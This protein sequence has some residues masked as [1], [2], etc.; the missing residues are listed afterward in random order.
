MLVFG[1]GLSSCGTG[2]TGVNGAE[3]QA[4]LP[5][6]EEA[7][8]T[9]SSPNAQGL[10]TIVGSDAVPDGATIIAD[11]NASTSLNLS[12]LR[13]LADLMIPTAA[14]SDCSSALEGLSECPDVNGEGKCYFVADAEGDASFQVPADVGDTIAI[15]YL[16]PSTCVETDVFEGA[17]IDDDT[18]SLGM[19]ALDTAFD[20]ENGRVYA[21]GIRTS[22]DTTTPFTYVYSVVDATTREVAA[23]EEISL[24]DSLVGI[25]E[26]VF[27]FPSQGG[28]DFFF[29]DGSDGVLI[30]D[31]TDATAGLPSFVEFTGVNGSESTDPDGDLDYLD[32]QDFDTATEA[33]CRTD[34]PEG[35]ESYTRIFYT[36][37][38][39]LFVQEFADIIDDVAPRMVSLSVT[40]SVAMDIAD[41]SYFHVGTS[42][43]E[44][45]EI[46]LGLQDVDA[47]TLLYYY[48]RANRSTFVSTLCGGLFEFN[49]DEGVS[50]DSLPDDDGAR[51]KRFT[52]DQ[53][54]I[55]THYLGI[56]NPTL[57]EFNFVNRDSAADCCDHLTYD[58]ETATMTRTTAT[59]IA[60]EFTLDLQ[61]YIKAFVPIENPLTGTSEV[62]L[63]ADGFGGSDFFLDSLEDS[64]FEPEDPMLAL[65]PLD[66][67]Y[68]ELTNELIAVDLG[69]LD[70]GEV[71]SIVRFYPVNDPTA[72]E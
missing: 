31:A 58:V 25:P 54:G 8:F 5:I 27:F 47:G 43:D 26:H 46:I 24:S 60:E 19:Y 32:A 63:L 40:A 53:D 28:R 62:F 33:A 44:F 34:L 37:G 7:G 57:Q 35:T 51:Y 4:S 15:S 49:L 66:V 68:N 41:V 16:D 42:E 72:S 50:L 55:T 11:V 36:D 67:F 17:E 18:P 10:V 71:A 23:E 59:A 21:I 9:I 22:D 45:A 70:S 2:T 12:P 48:F 20:D 30:A 29:I 61:S 6:S 14:A 1:L 69:L 38:V 65:Y 52:A 64:V 3:T 39:N 56:F 13:F